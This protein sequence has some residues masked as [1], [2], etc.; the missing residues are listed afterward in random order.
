LLHKD[1]KIVRELARQ[2]GTDASIIEK[3][4]ADYAVLMARGHGD[5]DISGLIRLKRAAA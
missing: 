1:L 2:A 5:D 3:C 4:L